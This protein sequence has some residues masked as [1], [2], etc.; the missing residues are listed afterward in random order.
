MFKEH[1]SSAKQELRIPPFIH[2][3]FSMNL[4]GPRRHYI[5][6]NKPSGDLIYMWNLKKSNS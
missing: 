2:L 1:V 5:K 6:C 4:D 3:Y